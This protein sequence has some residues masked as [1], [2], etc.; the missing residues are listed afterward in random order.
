M[1]TQIVHDQ[2]RSERRSDDFRYGDEYRVSGRF[3]LTTDRVDAVGII[4]T[5]S[6]ELIGSGNGNPVRSSIED[7]RADISQA[8][9]DSLDS[10]SSGLSA[11]LL[12][13]DRTKLPT[14]TITDFRA[15]GLSHILAISGLHITMVGGIIMAMSA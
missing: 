12:V 9:T 5:S 13:G 14:E 10:K 6:V 1:Y 2:T 8:L 4:S 7:F 3:I 11:A 15:S